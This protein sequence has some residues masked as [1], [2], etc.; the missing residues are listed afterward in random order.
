MDGVP[1][2]VSGSSDRPD[3]SQIRHGIIIDMMTDVVATQG[4]HLLPA[5]STPAVCKGFDSDFYEDLCHRLQRLHDQDLV[6]QKLYDHDA[7]NSRYG[8]TPPTVRAQY[9]SEDHNAMREFMELLEPATPS[10]PDSNI[11]DDSRSPSI[12]AQPS[13]RTTVSP[14]TIS[15]KPP[16]TKPSEGTG[17]GSMGIDMKRKHNDEE[18][19]VEDRTNNHSAPKKSHCVHL[20]RSKRL[21][22]LYLSKP[23]LSHL[24]L[25]GP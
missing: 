20:R 21:R 18:D 2:N 6:R 25:P 23:S 5:T 17:R 24:S 9:Q 15:P 8:H 14:V 10:T 16:H 12:S 13:P 3:S 11:H 7:L 4:R 19:A 22:T 1:A